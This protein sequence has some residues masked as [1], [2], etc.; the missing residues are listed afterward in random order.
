MADHAC[1]MCDA[2]LGVNVRP[3]RRFCCSLCR[4]AF[5]RG[6]R[7]L[8]EELYA[9]GAVDIATIRRH[10]AIVETIQTGE[11]SPDLSQ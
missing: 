2:S 4:A 1:L 9:S 5:H 7:M 8:G 3:G 11:T 6:C 10:S